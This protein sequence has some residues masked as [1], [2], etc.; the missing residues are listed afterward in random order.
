MPPTWVQEPFS[1]IFF[2]RA[3]PH[4]RVSSFTPR[5]RQH[6]R[7]P[8][9]RQDRHFPARLPFPEATHGAESEECSPPIAVQH[10]GGRCTALRPPLTVLRLNKSQLI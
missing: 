1:N 6:L 5:T 3:P 4:R 7:K 2:S 8:H 10:A 9:R